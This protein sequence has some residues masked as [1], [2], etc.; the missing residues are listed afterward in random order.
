MHTSRSAWLPLSCLLTMVVVATGCEQ[1][2]AT[3]ELGGA[4]L[5]SD[6]VIPTGQTCS[7]TGAHAKHAALTGC[8]TC[9]NCGGVLQF[10]PAGA[11]VVPGGPLPAFD[12]VAKTCSNVACHRVPTG[13][14]SYWFPGGDGEP[15]Y[16][17]VTYGGGA[18]RPTP[19]WYTAGAGCTAC[20]DNPPRDGST[21]SDV[22][23]SGY[24]GGQGPTGA[25]NQCQLCHPDAYGTSG[26]G[27][28]I[29]N[30]ALHA[31]GSATVQASFSSV[32]FGCH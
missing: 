6:E 8:T 17:T 15:V 1:P 2:G 26:V 12:A 3:A 7:P 24:H 27:T 14:F 11:A 4:A 19:S 25:R 18:P 10:D 23:H 16:N 9:H 20:H 21:G 22:W 32:C 28:A 30:A 29:T 13:T 31:N 5:T